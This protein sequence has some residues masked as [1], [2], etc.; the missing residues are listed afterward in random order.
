MKSSTAEIKLLIIFC[1]FFLITALSQ[2]AFTVSL[3]NQPSLKAELA[4]YFFCEAAGMSGPTCE[5]SFE[6]I[7]GE[8]PIMIG[9]ILLGLYPIVT[10]IYVVNVKRLMVHCCGKKESS[11]AHHNVNYSSSTLQKQNGCFNPARVISIAASEL[12]LSHAY[13]D[14]HIDSVALDSKQLATHGHMLSQLQVHYQTMCMH[15]SR[16]MTSIM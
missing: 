14:Q 6:R 2:T 13:A 3:S 10:L 8:I 16:S 4:E 9:F 11:S 7:S 5:R 12:I 15:T 1:Y